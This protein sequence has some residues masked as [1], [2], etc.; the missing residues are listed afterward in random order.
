[1]FFPFLLSFLV[2]LT[3]SYAAPA[4]TNPLSAR[5]TGTI[6]TSIAPS[7]WFKKWPGPTILLSSPN[8][9]QANGIYLDSDPDWNATPINT[10]VS[11][12]FSFSASLSSSAPTSASDLK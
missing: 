11:R 2:L 3:N 7:N 1:M 9:P 5:Q 10:F 8:S 4:K 6:A 12:P